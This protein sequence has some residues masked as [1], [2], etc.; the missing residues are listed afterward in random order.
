MK[1]FFEK[2]I[3]KL[4]D[5]SDEVRE[6]SSDELF[7]EVMNCFNNSNSSITAGDLV[8]LG[9]SK[10]QVH[11]FFA[12]F[13]NKSTTLYDEYARPYRVYR[14]CIIQ[15]CNTVSSSCGPFEDDMFTLSLYKGGL[16]T[17]RPQ[18]HMSAVIPESCATCDQ[19]LFDADDLFYCLGD[20]D[21]IKRPKNQMAIMVCDSHCSDSDDKSRQ[22]LGIDSIISF[23]EDPIYLSR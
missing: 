4:N 6:A 23:E 7:E 17:Y 19:I 15:N 10:I 11:A 8:G 14:N 21:A 2:A 18:R 12:L 20:V 5:F 13:S 16:T 1:T 22:R 3:K 9:F